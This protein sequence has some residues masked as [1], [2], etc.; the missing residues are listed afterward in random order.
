MCHMGQTP[1]HLQRGRGWCTNRLRGTVRVKYPVHPP[2]TTSPTRPRGPTVVS[3]HALRDR[4]RDTLINTFVPTYASMNSQS[5]QRVES[6]GMWRIPH[7]APL[8][9]TS[10]GALR[11]GRRG[12]GVTVNHYFPPWLLFIGSAFQRRRGA[13]A[14]LLLS[15]SA[16]DG[17]G[18]KQWQSYIQ[19]NCSFTAISWVWGI[20]WRSAWLTSDETYGHPWWSSFRPVTK[21]PFK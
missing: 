6:L 13:R 12:S 16:Q 8:E 20:E 1:T 18:S 7:T 3:A 5:H 10:R 4:H 9:A 17:C 21:C 14:W 15:N 11:C 2:T 19:F